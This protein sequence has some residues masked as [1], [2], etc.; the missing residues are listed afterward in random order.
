MFGAN[1][2]VA[3]AFAPKGIYAAFGVDAI[4]A[5]KE[6]L[7]S[8]GGP[9]PALDVVI[10]PSRLA[11]VFTA[12]GGNA[13]DITEFFGPDASPFT[14]GSLSIEGGAELKLRLMLNLKLFRAL[15]VTRASSAPAQPGIKKE[16]IKE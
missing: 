8:K 9:A 7:A 6:A 1:A 3:V 15:F 14:A 16:I 2:T 10:N 12:A 5:V 11:K 4:G 13:N